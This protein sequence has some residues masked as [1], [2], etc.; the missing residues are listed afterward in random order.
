MPVNTTGQQP[1]QVFLPS[2]FNYQYE[3]DLNMLVPRAYPKFIKQF[4]SLASKN[5]IVLR[6][7][8]GS[9]T[10]TNNKNFY[11]WTQKGKNA[12]LFRV[13][14][15]ATPGASSGTIQ[16]SSTY[17]MD[18]NTLSPFGNGWFY[19]NQTS[20]QVIQLTNVTIGGGIITA[21]A[22]TTDGTNLSIATTDDLTWAATVVGEA[23]G[24][25]STMSTVDV[26]VQNACATIKTTQTF[27]D[28][29][30][31]ERLDIPNDPAG[32]NKIRYRQQADERDRFLFQQEDLTMFGKP[33]TNI[34]GVT[35]NHT[36]LLYQIINNGQTDTASTVVNQAY[37]DNWRRLINAQGYSNDYDCL[38][39]VELRMKWENF[40]MSTYNAG[41]L[42]LAGEAQMKKGQ[43]ELVRNFTSYSLHGI[44]LHMFTYDYFSSANLYGAAP[45]SGLWN[46][47]V[48]MIPN[49][50]G[51]DPETQVNVPRFNIRWQGVT[52]GDAPI[53][54]RVTGGLAPIPTDDIEHLIVSSVTTKGIQPFGINGYMYGQLAA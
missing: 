47:T 11:Y 8:M 12:P 53:K 37:F 38:L 9:G 13:A 20:G 5:Y 43:T 28:W 3:S 54:L 36:G 33:F 14:I 29:S 32:F 1:S 18:A 35:N 39:D 6:E 42:V 44:A 49:G 22:T 51:I 50:M 24:S 21:T 16:C 26:K 10:Y 31:F 52:E 30:M 40:F 48:A 27:S 45:N 7:A 46:N 15:N 34:S 4:P 25:Q 2:G 17:I 19:R 41:T 23:S